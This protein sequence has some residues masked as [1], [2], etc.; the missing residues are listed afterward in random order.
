[1]SSWEV[2][3]ESGQGRSWDIKLSEC[4]EE[5]LVVNR[6]KAA[7]RSSSNRAEDWPAARV[8]RS[9][10]IIGRGVVSVEWPC[11]TRWWDGGYNEIC[12]N[13]VSSDWFSTVTQAQHLAIAL[14][15]SSDP[16]PGNEFEKSSKVVFKCPHNVRHMLIRS[17]LILAKS[18][19]FFD[20]PGNYRC[21][22]CICHICG[23]HTDSPLEE[24]Q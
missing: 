1:M 19:I 22:S 21:V 17:N 2:G 23:P 9:D 20:P 11:Q 8:Q 7:D 13:T 16:L 10:S 14:L 5:D 18:T 12:L 15:F 3:D 24:N 4:V 6:V